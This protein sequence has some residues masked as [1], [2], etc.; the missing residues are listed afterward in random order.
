MAIESKSAD[1]PPISVF[2]G[3]PSSAIFLFCFAQKRYVAMRMCVGSPEPMIFV[4][5]LRQKLLGKRKRRGQA[6][7]EIE[8]D[9][10]EGRK[11]LDPPVFRFF[12]LK[13]SFLFSSSS[14]SSFLEKKKERGG[15]LTAFS[16]HRQKGWGWALGKGSGAEGRGTLA[17]RA[18]MSPIGRH[19]PTTTQFALFKT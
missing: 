6:E 16:S 10:G 5:E 1:R 4:Q 17:N 18:R 2:I 13:K 19:H 12:F 11:L 14:S 8:M 3:V 9:M 15:G 7:M